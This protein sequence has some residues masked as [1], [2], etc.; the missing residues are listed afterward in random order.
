MREHQ[1]RERE[2]ASH[3]T[4]EAA[5]HATK[6]LDKAR[7]QFLRDEA[8]AAGKQSKQYQ[9]AAKDD[10]PVD[11][12]ERMNK[13]DTAFAKADTK[14]GKKLAKGRT[15]AAKDLEHAEAKARNR[16][17]MTG[18][19]GSHAVGTGVGT[20]VGAA[21]GIAAGSMAGP[22]GA[23]VG[24]VV[25]AVAGAAAGHGVGEAVNPTIEEDYWRS[26]YGMEPY[27]NSKYSYDDYAPAYRA[28]FMGY[29]AY[30]DLTWDEAESRI[31]SDWHALRGNSRLEWKQARKASRAAWERLEIASR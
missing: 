30:P 26:A 7:E 28:G 18:A 8:K 31:A 6:H 12:I 14:A 3:I 5:H 29:D 2:R 4:S 15:K 17:P 11:A 21:A 10:D 25:G 22:G 27:Y 16:D 1:Q 24:G 23:A 19:P 20:A 9:K 13:A